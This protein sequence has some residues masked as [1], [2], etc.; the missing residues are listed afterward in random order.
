[1]E[2]QEPQKELEILEQ[3]T[4]KGKQVEP[5][6]TA[7]I[8]KRGGFYHCTDRLPNGKRCKAKFTE[9]R[10]LGR[11]RTTHGVLGTGSSSVKKRG[12]KQR[13][14]TQ[15]E[16]TP[17]SI[18]VYRT[19]G[20][21]PC[22]VPDCVFDSASSFG[23]KTHLRSKHRI[24]QVI[25]GKKSDQEGENNGGID[26]S[27]TTRLVKAKKNGK[28]N[29]WSPEALSG[30]LYAHLDTHLENASQ[31]DPSTR[32][33]IS[34]RLTEFL[35]HSVLRSGLQDREGSVRNAEHLSPMFRET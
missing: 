13:E 17:Q 18:T 21:Y 10:F 25:L 20:S 5:V 35:S 16:Q 26:S 28:G 3:T 12:K 7:D 23:V 29:P 15:R 32:A 22:P 27:P 31:G 30:F 33:H 2:T 14:Q 11:H 24:L 34:H 6:S 1:M 19:N 8:A 4:K 9:R